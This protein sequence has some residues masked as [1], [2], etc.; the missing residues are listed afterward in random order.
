[1]TT[2]PDE[3]KDDAVIG[4]ALRRSLAV[5][6]V[7]GVVIAG[8]LAAREWLRPPKAVIPPAT[9]KPPETRVRPVVE[10]PNLPFTDITASSGVTFRY[11]N[12]AAGEKLLP[13]TMGGG[14][15]LL[16]YDSDG[17]QDL[18]FVNSC[19]WPWDPRSQGTDQPTMALYAND[20]QA[21]FTDV[22]SAAGLNITFYGQGVAVGDYDNDGDPDLFFSAVGTNHLLRNDGGKYLDVTT[23]TGV[24]GSPDQWTSSCGW[25][26]YDNDGDLDLFV[27]RYVQWTRDFDRQQNF[28]LTG[29]GRAY[30]RPQNFPGT[31][32]SLY[33]NDGG[34]FTDVAKEA[35]LH[36]VNPATEVPAAK[37]LGVTFVDID[38]DGWLDILVANDTVQNFLFHNRQNGT[39]TEIG[40]LAGV[41]YDNEGN[42][43]GAMGI[44]AARFRNGDQLGIAI[45]NFSNEMTAL[46]VS[47]GG[48]QFVDEAVAS[49]LGP[50]T[51]LE[52]TFGTLFF[53]A[54]L[55]GRLDIASA[56]GH[57]EE[58]INRVQPS[59]HY[60]QSPHFFWNC[61][62]EEPTEFAPVPK[63]KAGE[64]YYQPFVGRG[65]TV[66]D[67]DGDGDLDLVFAASGQ[68][69]RILRNDQQTGHHWLRVRLTGSR[70]NRDA[71]GT[72]VRADAQTALLIP[73]RSYLAQT[74]RV[75]TFGLGAQDVVH[76]LTIKWP[77][78]TTQELKDV[79][80]NQTLNLT[81][82][83]R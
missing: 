34:R 68:T 30:G 64:A 10:I 41:A 38:R 80:T 51:R 29:G 67:L 15:A 27:A 35:G 61:G 82:P 56:N 60:A 47:Q 74:E 18:L 52:L 73:T 9:V 24:A 36:V 21:H 50:Q 11:Q 83:D 12:G 4:V 32:P 23:E 26:D 54:D 20:G 22:T 42:A 65:A 77:G 78:G 44:D 59:Q 57:L 63:S 48:M 8:G 45:G 43:R 7:I 62:P 69:P 55:D 3:E 25:L 72:E 31:F 53:D 19:Y 1:M 16:D 81:E 79:T 70:S 58:E 66:G 46:Y 40:V 6:I 5:I 17:D 37:A 49:G 33:R 75:I 13:E 71:I 39:F 14:C 2:G 28:Q 76:N